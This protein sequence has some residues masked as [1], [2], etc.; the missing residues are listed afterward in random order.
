[1]R[2]STNTSISSKRLKARLQSLDKLSVFQKQPDVVG[3]ASHLAEMLPE[4]LSIQD[5]LDIVEGTIMP[6]VANGTEASDCPCGAPH[7]RFDLMRF[8]MLERAMID[9]TQHTGPKSLYGAVCNWYDSYYSA[10]QEMLN[11]S[12]YRIIKNFPN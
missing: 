11:R 8:L 6:Y 10:R 5:F 12:P 1:M 9:V 3:F 7:L 2:S 4:Q